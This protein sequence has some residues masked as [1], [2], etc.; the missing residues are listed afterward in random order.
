MSLTGDAAAGDPVV[1]VLKR[2]NE[3][4][5]ATVITLLVRRVEWK[6]R[7]LAFLSPT[8]RFHPLEARARMSCRIQMSVCINLLYRSTTTIASL[9]DLGNAEAETSFV[10]MTGTQSDSGSGSGI[11]KEVRLLM[12]QN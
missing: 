2:P 7:S 1:N 9:C 10:A 11:G 4:Q 12:G 6:R 5:Y 8:I 3:D